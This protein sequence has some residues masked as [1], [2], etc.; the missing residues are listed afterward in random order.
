METMPLFAHNFGWMMLNALL[1][2]VPIILVIIMRRKLNIILYLALFFLWLIFLPNAVYLITDVQ[3]LPKQLLASNGML[4][5]L[6]LLMQYALLAAFG[7]MTYVYAL[8][9]ASKVL[10]RL[11][12]P[13][14]KQEITFIAINYVVAF[15]VMVGKFQRTH[16]WYI[17][18]E[19]QRVVGDVLNT[20][21]N[22]ELLGWVFVFGSIVNVV[23]FLFKDYFPPLGGKG[24]I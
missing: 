12:F 9:P 19:P 7:V 1:A 18:T 15:G 22:I 20:A 10:K 5:Q 3:H 4:E 6:F 14:V 21:F 13:E 23:F 24:R 2:F 8:E 11:K 17:F 16:S